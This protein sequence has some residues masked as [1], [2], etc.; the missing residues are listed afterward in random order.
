MHERTA[1]I[2]LASQEHRLVVVAARARQGLVE[3]R[4][5]LANHLRAQLEDF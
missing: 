4:V 1:A 5:S 2:D 3:Q